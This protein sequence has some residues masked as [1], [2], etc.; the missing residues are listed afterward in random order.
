MNITIDGFTVEAISGETVMTAAKRAGIFIPGLCCD[1]ATGGHHSCRLCMVEIVERGREKLVAACAY[2]VKEAMVVSTTSDRVNRIRATLLGLLYLQ[3]PDDPQILEL[4]Q[5][6]AVSPPSSLPRKEKGKTGIDA[7]ILCYRCVNACAR[8]G[9]AAISTVSRGVTKAIDTPYSKASDDC[10]G[11]SACAQACPLQ[12]ISVED[13]EATRTIWNRTFHLLKCESCGAII[14][15]EEHYQATERALLAK[16]PNQK[17][18]QIL[19]AACKRKKMTGV[20]AG[21]LGEI[22]R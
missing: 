6:Y 7:C 19:C 18:T 21:S 13:T 16:D 4:M 14:S 10:I 17:P 1:E 8:L 12:S 3:A 9:A 20:F 22:E 2:P 15:T 11:C 5:Q